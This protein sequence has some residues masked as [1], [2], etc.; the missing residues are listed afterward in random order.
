MAKGF[1]KQLKRNASIFC[2]SLFSGLRNADKAMLAQVGSGS[3]KDTEINHTQEADCVMNDLLKGEVTDRVKE[4]RDKYYRIL[5]ESDKYIVQGW[6]SRE[7]FEKWENDKEGNPEEYKR[8]SVIKYGRFDHKHVPVYEPDTELEVMMI[9]D[10]YDLDS[11]TLSVSEAERDGRVWRDSNGIS[12]IYP[13]RTIRFEWDGIVPRFKYEQYLTRVV[14]RGKDGKVEKIDLYF[15]VPPKPGDEALFD[16]YD[17]KVSSF[18]ADMKHQ[19]ENKF[20]RGDLCYIRGLKWTTSKAWGEKDLRNIF[21]DNPKVDSIA[22]YD[23]KYVITMIPEEVHNV[24][25]GEKYKM[26]EVT[27]KYK[28]KAPIH[29]ETL[30]LSIIAREKERKQ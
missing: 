10:N 4:L 12:H 25:I 2:A 6:P 28:E 14:L 26:E 1:L 24:Y 5:D 22:E 21:V 29:P 13:Y 17:G 3:V 11:S 15:P 7:E 23:G 20:Y 16:N 27:K 19:Y 9:Q 18:M 30:D 8:Y